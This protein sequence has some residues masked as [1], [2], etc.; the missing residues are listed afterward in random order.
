MDPNLKRRIERR[1]EAV[2]GVLARSGDPERGRSESRPSVKHGGDQGV[3]SM[4][5]IHN[6]AGF[7]GRILPHF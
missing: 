3:N 5:Q 2:K 7:P 1:G 4:P 6:K